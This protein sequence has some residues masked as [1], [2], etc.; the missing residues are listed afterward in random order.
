MYISSPDLAL[1]HL[2]SLE[3]SPSSPEIRKNS[4]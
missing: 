2:G 1:V 4:F 3:L